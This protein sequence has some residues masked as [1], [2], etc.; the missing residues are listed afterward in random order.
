MVRPMVQFTDYLKDERGAVSV[1]YTVLS[2]AA[3]G[4]AIAATA[5]LVVGID[6]LT[7]RV[8]AELRDRQLN[9]EFIGFLSSH[10]NPL[11]SEGLVTEA[12]AETLWTVADTKMNQQLI[13]QLVTGITAIEDGTIER[14][15]MPELY[16]A[17]SVAYQR[18]IIDDAVLEYYF[19]FDDG[20]DD[21]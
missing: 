19:G 14:E 17:A 2:A 13:D 20:V 7:G 4:V 8:D 3:V 10:F 1:D 6:T 15:D 9:D 16:A 5:V 21:G 18:N 12:Q 11:Y